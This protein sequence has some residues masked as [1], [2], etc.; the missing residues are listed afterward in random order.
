MT[1]IIKFIDNQ[2]MAIK[3]LN[4]SPITGANSKN[5]EYLIYIKKLPETDNKLL[6]WNKKINQIV[7]HAHKELMKDE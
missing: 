1:K 3:G 7:N 4:Y 6:D 2:G 5:I